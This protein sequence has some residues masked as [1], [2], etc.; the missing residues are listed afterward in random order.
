MSSNHHEKKNNW[1]LCIFETEVCVHEQWEKKRIFIEFYTFQDQ[2]HFAY[3]WGSKKGFKN[4]FK[5]SNK[6]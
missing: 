6:N 1:L 5:I 3:F 2:S 4:D